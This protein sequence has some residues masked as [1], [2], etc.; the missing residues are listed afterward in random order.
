MDKLWSPWRSK[1]IDSFKPGGDKEEGCLFCRINDEKK[2]KENYV[3]HR[4]TYCF[5]VMN[6]YPYNSGH[7]MIV[8]YI[9]SSTLN[10]LNDE[11][12]LDCMKMINLSCDVLSDA[13][14]PHGFNIGANIGK[15]SGAGIDEHVHFHLVPRWNGD[16]N[17]MPVLNEVKIISEFMDITYEKI[18][19]SL[20]SFLRKQ[21]SR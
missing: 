4:S 9:H 1:Y 17:F 8:P 15:V 10:E 11:T 20:T 2:D 5:I 19:K 13:I 18:M 21:E 12:Y 7:L 6:L 16:T 3:I 14:Y